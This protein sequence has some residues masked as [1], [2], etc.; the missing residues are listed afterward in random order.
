MIVNNYDKALQKLLVSSFE[1]LV[2]LELNQNL[3][4]NDI[5][6]NDRVFKGKLIDRGDNFI[7]FFLNNLRNE[8]I[9]YISTLDDKPKSLEFKIDNTLYKID[10]IKA[11]NQ[12]HISYI[13]SMQILTKAG[14]VKDSEVTETLIFENLLNTIMRHF[15]KIESKSI[16]QSLNFS[17]GQIARIL[18][19]DRCFLY[20]NYDNNKD[21]VP[22]VVWTSDEVSYDN[23]L[24]D[25]SLIKEI[26]EKIKTE[27]VLI[28]KPYN[29]QEIFKGKDV[30]YLDDNKV[31]T[32]FVMSLSDGRELN[33]FLIF[34][35]KNKDI[36]LSGDDIRVLVSFS[37]VLSNIIKRIHNERLSEKNIKHLEIINKNKS[38]FLLLTA[39]QL[40]TP[41]NSVIGFLQI[42]KR[43]MQITNE[44]SKLFSYIESGLMQINNNLDNI[45]DISKIENNLYLFKHEICTVESIID[46]ISN[47]FREISLEKSTPIKFFCE[48]DFDKILYIDTSGLISAVKTIF[49]YFNKAYSNNIFTVRV[50]QKKGFLRLLI[51]NKNFPL[52]ANFT[53][54]FYKPY[55]ALSLENSDYNTLF[56]LY[57]SK[58]IL[59]KTGIDFHIASNT[60]KGSYFWFNLKDSDYVSDKFRL[61]KEILSINKKSINLAV[62]EKS[63]YTF[64]EFEKL[65]SKYSIKFSYFKNLHDFNLQ[66]ESH[67]FDALFI[68]P[69]ELSH[70]NSNEQLEFIAKDTPVVLLTDCKKPF[71]YPAENE[72]F[73]N[74][75]VFKNKLKPDYFLIF[76][77]F[78]L[79]LE[80][81][82]HDETLNNKNY[83]QTIFKML[84][85][86]PDKSEL[87]HLKYLLSNY[88]YDEIL[89]SYI[90]SEVKKNVKFMEIL[91]K[92]FKKAD[93][94]FLTEFIEYL[95][96]NN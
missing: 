17:L 8:L 20:E 19:F 28:I 4:I 42:L 32:I 11:N 78:I 27:R 83:K 40:R 38:D 50:L 71:V 41:L 52:Q 49:E 87:Y 35:S 82:Y 13:V 86:I 1:H 62:I 75:P 14:S 18:A 43:N 21:F 58:M 88:H 57:I 79:K 84:E 37:E 59:S 51:I 92:A 73:I 65:F 54:G 10:I 45:T 7:D 55:S 16:I 64:K 30:W 68:N 72:D 3:I 2:F 93:F 67:K 69:D 24:I 66:N 95:L 47:V 70:E 25:L 94:E 29:I 74:Y 48:V 53:K 33:G 63:I 23:K 22:L 26:Q 81:T 89:E 61:D 76:L 96:N 34:E 56:S 90:Y 46:K 85:E 6:G 39:H 5:F 31:K 80:I 91:E 36:L 9:E 44:E 60:D 12:E 77:I 15:I